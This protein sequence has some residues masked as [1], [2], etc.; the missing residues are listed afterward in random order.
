MGGATGEAYS[1]ILLGT[2]M[3]PSAVLAREAIQNSVDA[4]ADEATD[5]VKV[6][7]RRV[8]LSGAAKERFVNTLAM[9]EAFSERHKVLD[10]QT[11]NCFLHL[12]DSSK[13][14]ELLYI[15]DFGTHGLFGDPHS[16]SSHFH[17]LLL[18]LGDGSKARQ[19]GSSGG[20]Y[21]YGKS[22]YSASS[23]I[24]TIVAYS[25]FG[26]DSGSGALTAR[27]MGCS[28]F[29]GH[30]FQCEN[31]TGR[32]WFG[33]PDRLDIDR[34]YPFEGSRAIDL[35]A[36]LDFLA[37][38][39]H[40]FGTSILIVDCPVDINGL[41]AAIEDWWWPRILEDDL[42]IEL[43]DG[44]T[45]VGPPRPRNRPDLRPFI[46]CFEMAINRSSPVGEH[47]KVVTFNRL[48]G[49]QLGSYG[50]TLLDE[51]EEPAEQYNLRRNSIALIR[52]PRMVVSYKPVSNLPLPCVGV[53]VAAADSDQALR[54]SEP[55]AHDRWDPT[56]SRFGDQLEREIVTTIDRR[57]VEH[58]KRFS[59]AAVPQAPAGDV[60]LNFLER[61]LGSIFRPPTSPGKVGGGYPADPIEIRFNG[62]PESMSVEGGICTNGS[63]S[64]ALASGSD[65]ERVC[66]S[67]DV[68]CLPIEGGRPAKEDPI[69]VRIIAENGDEHFI[70]PALPGRVIVDLS[71]STR[72]TFSFVSDPYPA[73]WTT[74]VA[75]LVKEVA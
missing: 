72:Y 17:R 53:F 5:K 7:F 74:S 3:D 39:A 21:G 58:F 19:D 37:R 70:D 65:K 51:D 29:K 34:V 46:H 9:D 55:P 26:V 18:S 6:I 73:D 20:S 10:L 28:Y 75:V 25:V 16:A 4:A 32:A 71:E 43:W 63:F 40:G 27:L 14:L 64:V 45:R 67:I 12:H 50:F 31:Y 69:S 56:S 68:Q 47:D 1:N 66:A 13:P 15:E 22:V 57:L 11:G 33:D 48:R 61:M 24:H 2:G 30:E 44:S 23:L 36:E 38:G 49:V 42:D 35:A 59:R 60:K 8:V 62:E 54:I 52:S 41:R